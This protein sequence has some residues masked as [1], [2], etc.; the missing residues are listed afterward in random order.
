[1]SRTVFCPEEVIVVSNGKE[2][3]GKIVELGND[4]KFDTSV[5]PMIDDLQDQIT[6]ENTARSDADKQL[7]TN[8]DTETSARI[9]ADQQL[10]SN[11]D[12]EA[13][14]RDTADKDLQD[15][16]AAEIA[17]RT[18]ADNQLQVNI[19]TELEARTTADQGLEDKIIAEI[20]ARTNADET[21]SNARVNAD[22]NLQEQIDVLEAKNA[23]S[24]VVV[25]G[26]A[27]QADSQEDT[28]EL[29][30]GTNIALTA[31][32]TN[33]KVTIAVTGK[34][35]SAAQADNASAADIA[36]KLATARSIN[37]VAFD[38]SADII[39]S[40]GI[41]P[42]GSIVMWSGSTDTIPADWALCNG[43]NGTPNLLDRMVVCAGESYTVGATGGEAS[44][45]LTADE[46]P[47][48][49][50]EFPGDDQYLNAFQASSSG[51]SRVE[52]IN[53]WDW[54]SGAASGNPNGWYNPGSKG[55][56]GGSAAHNNMPPYYALAYIMRIA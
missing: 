2:D 35:A 9:S 17:A 13:T 55:C 46:M 7:Q 44:H 30:A 11:I 1:M 19:D 12:V 25:N 18:N 39:I 3:I 47:S 54:T 22:Q 32:T 26:T 20:T 16:I 31:D 33:E 48:H 4:G 41:V 21:E 56:T 52:A 27:I 50:H 51:L 28:I 43:S 15:K 34:V 37:G 8:I 6:A 36:T 45:T 53:N 10:Q 40:T 29:E 23:F 24:N 14:T 5:I 49:Y 42:I 38:G